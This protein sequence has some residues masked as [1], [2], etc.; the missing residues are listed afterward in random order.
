MKAKQTVAEK[1]F[2]LTFI[3]LEIKSIIKN[4]I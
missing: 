3:H 4:F 2:R 1:L